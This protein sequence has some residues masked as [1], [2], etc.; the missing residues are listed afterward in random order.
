MQLI[1]VTN[2]NLNENEDEKYTDIIH[3]LWH[4]KINENVVVSMTWKVVHKPLDTTRV[5]SQSNKLKTMLN[6]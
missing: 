5:Q 4:P 6:N 1:F 3:F 2:V